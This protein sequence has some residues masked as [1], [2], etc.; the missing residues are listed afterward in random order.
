MH[1]RQELA[2]GYAR[3]RSSEEREAVAIEGADTTHP[4]AAGL[5]GRSEHGQKQIRE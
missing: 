3:P 2:H 4:I 1:Q 5:R